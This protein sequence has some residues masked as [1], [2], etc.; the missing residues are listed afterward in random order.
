MRWRRTDAASTDARA[1]YMKLIRNKRYLIIPL[2]ANGKERIDVSI[3]AFDLT[4]CLC[5]LR[6]KIPGRESRH[7]TSVSAQLVMKL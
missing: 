7:G 1:A 6:H 4:G 2:V 5:D 3:I